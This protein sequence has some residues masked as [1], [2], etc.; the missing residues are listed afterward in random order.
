[1]SIAEGF[2]ATDIL[3][4]TIVQA[5]P[6]PEARKPAIKL[7]IDFGAAVGHKW[8]SAQVTTYYEPVTL[9]GRQVIAAM[10]LGPK[11]IAGFTS[12]VL[13][14]GVME[15]PTTVVLLTPERP[16]PNGARIA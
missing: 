13:V 1:M 16:T 4:G 7:E 11:R 15:N 9:V 12:E 2:F 5:L 8:S 6:F 3:V 14:L 10:N